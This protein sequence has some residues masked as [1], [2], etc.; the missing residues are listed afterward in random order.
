MTDEREPLVNEATSPPDEFRLHTTSSQP[1]DA[2]SSNRPTAASVWREFASV[3]AR[4]VDSHAALTEMTRMIANQL[5]VDVCSIY[6][7]DDDNGDLVLSAT[8]GLNQDSVGTVR[9]S[10]GNGLVGLVAQELQPVYVADAPG[11]HR[12]LHFPDVG[13]DPFVSF[14]GVPILHR[15]NFRGVLVVQTAEPRN[16]THDWA[17]IATAAQ[18]IAPY[19]GG[20]PKSRPVV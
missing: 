14:F 11:H 8:M 9:M 4:H 19:V 13:E 7:L 2:S 20:P 10:P 3:A 12:F 1:Q 18:R 17:S 15:G 5:D 6:V 16:L